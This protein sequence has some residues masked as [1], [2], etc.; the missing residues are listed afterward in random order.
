MGFI[1]TE[2]ESFK[3]KCRNCGGDIHLIGGENERAGDVHACPYCACILSDCEPTENDIQRTI[4]ELE[5]AIAGF[6]AATDVHEK[7]TLQLSVRHYA[8]AL[9]NEMA[10][11]GK[12]QSIFHDWFCTACG[13]SG[14]E[15]VFPLPPNNTDQDAAC[16]VCGKLALEKSTW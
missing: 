6:Q 9:S 8:Y 1:I 16:P 10:M 2:G 3:K 11:F 13:W 7:K 5:K 14:Y 4:K 15:P 12:D